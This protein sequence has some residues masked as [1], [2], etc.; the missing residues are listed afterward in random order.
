MSHITAGKASPLLLAAATAV[1]AA[2][3]FTLAA[4]A[5]A[6]CRYEFPGSFVL[7][8]SNGFRVEFPATGQNTSGK[9]VAYNNRQQVANAGDATA[10]I[11]GSDVNITIGWE[12]GA[13]GRYTGTV[14]ENR[15]VAGQTQDLANG[16][17]AS[18]E[19]V[20][21]LNCAPEQAPSP[22]PGPTPPADAPPSAT[23]NGDVDL[24]D[25]PGGDGNVIGILRKG[26][27]VQLPRPCPANQWCEVSGRGWVWG[28]FLQ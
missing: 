1:G 3:L 13:V 10:F 17:S 14:R 7:N 25:A 26:E 27:Q 22:T 24:Y 8:Q 5:Q 11:N 28:D 12:G 21:A 15:T 6:A 2:G 23:V 18:W 9:A 4:P 16:S 20:T 19:S